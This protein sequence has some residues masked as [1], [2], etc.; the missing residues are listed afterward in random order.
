MIENRIREIVNGWIVEEAPATVRMSILPEHK[1]ALIRRLKVYVE[2]TAY[3]AY[4][5]GYNDRSEDE[6]K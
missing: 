3:A 2:N 6:K 5:D 4:D 1:E